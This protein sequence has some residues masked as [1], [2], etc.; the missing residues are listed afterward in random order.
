MSP[1]KEFADEGSRWFDLQRSGN[2]LTIMNKWPIILFIRCLRRSWMPHLVYT[3]KI[4]GT[5][6]SDEK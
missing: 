3:R 5:E 6:R 1:Y 4:W 2:L